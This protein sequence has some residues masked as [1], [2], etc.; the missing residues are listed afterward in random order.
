[1]PVKTHPGPER[2]LDYL[3]QQ[4]AAQQQ[5][6]LNDAWSLHITNTGFVWK[7]LDVGGG[8]RAPL[9]RWHFAAGAYN[10]SEALV[11]FGGEAR[12][13]VLGDVWSFAP[14]LAAAAAPLPAAAIPS[15][16]MASTPIA[17]P[18]LPPLP[19][20]WFKLRNGTAAAAAAANGGS[21]S[22]PG[23]RLSAAAAVTGG[24]VLVVNG[25]K[26]PG[27]EFGCDARTF[28]LDL[29]GGAAAAGEWM[30]R[31]PLPGLC[32]W[33]HTLTRV[34]VT[35]TPDSS[36]QAGGVA[37]GGGG[38]GGSPPADAVAPRERLVAY[39]GRHC[40]S[41]GC[42]LF[43]DLWAYDAA[44]DAWERLDPVMDAEGETGIV[45]EERL[46]PIMDVE[47]E[48]GVVQEAR[49]D[50]IMATE[51]EA[52]IV[53][54]APL[55][56]EQ[57]GAVFVQELDSL[58]IHG[59]RWTDQPGP[60]LDDIWSFNF[61]TRRWS[62]HWQLPNGRPPPRFGHGFA[63]WQG[64]QGDGS[65]GL[66]VIGGEVIE[67]GARYLSNDVWMYSIQDRSWRQVGL[68]DCAPGATGRARA[69]PPL[70]LGALLA[71]AFAAVFVAMALLISRIESRRSK[72]G[73]LYVGDI[74]TLHAA[75]AAPAPLS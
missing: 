37:T 75:A 58:F 51:G 28:A 19:Q 22:G 25:G 12:G 4:P 54:E 61:K 24:G 9:P 65:P 46:G 55:P 16:T 15:A 43:S 39:G 49:L 45:R 10:D 63:V 31:A 6:F 70:P 20:P 2:R 11:V 38:G 21:N 41:E 52:G 17:P 7:E 47:E 67:S 35:P 68:N 1:M 48:A 66:V 59:G 5:A 53:R 33:G 14:Q 27:A 62:Q 64:G 23:P 56:R 18:L 36:A 3:V 26:A 34:T 69:P 57:H 71:V 72:D 8:R 29:G 74:E 40:G 73:Y 50:S 32:R 42:Q 30:P 13:G 60:A 44:A